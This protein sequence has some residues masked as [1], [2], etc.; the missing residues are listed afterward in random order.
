MFLGTSLAAFFANTTLLNFLSTQLPAEKDPDGIFDQPFKKYYDYIVVGAGSA[1]SIIATRL[2][3]DRT[4][5]LLLEAGGSDLENEFT[6]IPLQWLRTLW[7]K[8]NW[9][10]DTVPQKYSVMS[11]GSRKTKGNCGKVLGGT[12]S[13]NG[14]YYIRGSRYDYDKW[15]TE[16]CTGWGYDD[17]LPYFKKSEDIQIPELINSSF[18]GHGGP[19][20]ITEGHTAPLEFL[21]RLAAKE[22]GL[23]VTDCNGFNQIGYC[24]IQ[25]NVKNGERC[26]S[27]SCFL[28]PKLHRRNLQVATNSHVTKIII[29]NGETKGVV[30]MKNGK[31][32]RIYARDEVIISA[33][34]FGS[35]K[36]LLL[37]GVGPRHHLE[38]LRVPLKADL[39]VG[40]GMQ[41]HMQ[42]FFQYSTTTSMNMNQEKA[43]DQQSIMDY[44]FYKKGVQTRSGI[45]GAIFARLPTNHDLDF[46]PDLQLTFIANAFEGENIKCAIQRMN[47]MG[48][49]G[50][51]SRSADF[52]FAVNICKLHHKSR[53][54]VRLRSKNPMAP[55]LIDPQYLANQDDVDSYVK[56]IRY[57]QEF[58]NNSAWNSIGTTFIRQEECTSFC[59][60]FTFDTDDYWKCMIR[61]YA[62]SSNHQVSTCRMGAL[63]DKTAVVDP[64]LRV[65]GIKNLRVADSSVMRNVPSGNT[66]APTMM[67]GEKAADMI[68]KS[69]HKRL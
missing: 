65:K 43:L 56:V 23:P 10:F 35:P 22:K 50:E 14:M 30:V 47:H 48:V 8:E 45:D 40:E 12:G 4:N 57:M 36:L 46:L 51:T 26:S 62:T 68:K 11:E 29:R 1:G 20:V 37:S 55:P 24:P 31:K 53:G 44:I 17:V 64:Y 63:H 6:R 28:R 2:S 15:Q 21:H 69:R 66:N 13:I 54:T 39:P 49:F 16:G 27:A 61:H 67:I 59:K 52:G 33:G 9:S 5:V 25:A 38:K 3:E 42:Y 32:T 7:T 18:H 58:A 19:L 34:V 41:Y 60:A